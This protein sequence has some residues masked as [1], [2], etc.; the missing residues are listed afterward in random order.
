MVPIYIIG[1]VVTDSGTKRKRYLKEVTEAGY[2]ICFMDGAT[3]VTE[4]GTFCW[5]TWKVLDV[6]NNKEKQ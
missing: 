6:E 3:S 4:S 1:G 5:C 2:A